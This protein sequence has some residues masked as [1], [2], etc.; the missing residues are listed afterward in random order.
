MS[1]SY[2]KTQLR[3]QLKAVLRSFDIETTTIKS[4]RASDFLLSHP[5]YAKARVLLSYC[6]M[7]H[8]ADPAFIWQQA[9]RDGKRVVFPYCD[10]KNRLLLPLEPWDKRAFAVSAHQISAP[11]P[12]RANLVPIEEIDF[13]IVPGL[14]FD[15]TGGRLGR[16]GGYY[17]R[18][19]QQTLAWR[20]G[21]CFE[22]Q[23]LPVVPMEVHDCRMHGLA[24]DTDC[25][26][27]V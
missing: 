26:S 10:S 3:N 15:A 13:I 7:P 8:E 17:D 22:E 14:A 11:M 23:V 2:E 25:R 20:M 27:F 21:F 16:G 19:L 5:A 24:S 9:L 4:R 6:A 18:F 1:H 12:E